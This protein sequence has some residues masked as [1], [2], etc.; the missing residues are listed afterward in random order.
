[1]Y[2]VKFLEDFFKFKQYVLFLNVGDN[3]Y[4][5]FRP[6]DVPLYDLQFNGGKC[7]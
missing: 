4:Y 7:R 2:L 5:C 1:M 3:Y 6:A